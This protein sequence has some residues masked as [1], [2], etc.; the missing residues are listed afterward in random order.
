MP[1]EN[2]ICRCGG[3]GWDGCKPVKRAAR[4]AEAQAVEVTERLDAHRER[5]RAAVRQRWR[6]S[7]RLPPAAPY[8]TTESPRAC[9]LA[10]RPESSARPRSRWR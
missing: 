8:W 9:S 1:D 4:T 7:R 10:Y 6:R 2:G 5:E 3:E